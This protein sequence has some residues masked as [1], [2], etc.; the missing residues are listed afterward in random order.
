MQLLHK[1]VAPP[2]EAREDWRIVAELARRMGAETGWSY[3]GT[4]DIM[5]EIAALTPSYAGIS[6]ERLEEG[7]LCWPCPSP[8]HP[9]TPILHIGGFTRGRG[10]F[11]PVAY[12]P[13][14]EEADDEY[15]LTLTT[16]RLLEHYHT[17]TMTRRSD[18][19]NELVPTGFAEINPV[20]A[21]RLGVADGE[22]V[23]V[24]TR[25]GAIRTPANVT[26]RVREGTVFVPFHFWEAPANRLTNPARDPQAKIPE[27]KVCACRVAVP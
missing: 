19:L 5:R 24:E 12:Q 8:E 25:R 11:F 1:A 14:D 23:V 10:R 13:P 16:G 20:D 17:G 22:E 9:G 6:H 18:G 27:F 21:A 15:P 4:A 7:G 2:G 3:P 26:A